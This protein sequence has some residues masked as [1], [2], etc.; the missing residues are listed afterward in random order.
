MNRFRATNVLRRHSLIKKVMSKKL[1][2]YVR[3]DK[4]YD[5]GFIKLITEDQFNEIKLK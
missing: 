4:D 1:L 5:N 2:H 3:S